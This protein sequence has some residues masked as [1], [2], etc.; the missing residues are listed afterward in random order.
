[1]IYSWLKV[2]AL[3]LVVAVVAGCS[4]PETP[5]EVA[6]EFWQA[7]AENDADAVIDLSTL[8]D[9]SDFDGFARDWVDTVPDFGRVIIDDREA[10]IVT[11]LP[12]DNGAAGERREVITYLV[13]LNGD[14]LV[15]YHRTGEAIMNPS[16]LKGLM[17][18]INKLGERLTATFSQSSGDIAS[19]M[20]ALSREFEAYSDQA[21]RRAEQAMKEY[22]RALQEFMKELEKSVEE[23]LEDNQQAPARDRSA[24]QQTAADLNQSSRRLEE[25]DFDAFADSTRALAEAGERFSRLSDDAFK[26]YQ[27]QWETRLDEIHDRTGAFFRDLEGAGQ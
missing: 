14:W 20:D 27:Q 4:K 1:M 8:A 2:W 15:D 16:P 3:V 25:P 17:G 19:Q 9:P 18:E 23:A 12:A 7:M 11:R 13:Q 22:G 24:L 5:R 10:T 6:A 21:S 26:R